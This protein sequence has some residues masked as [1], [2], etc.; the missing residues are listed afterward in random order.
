MRPWKV[1]LTGDRYDIRNSGHIKDFTDANEPPNST[2]G[3]ATIG[4]IVLIV[5]KSGNKTPKTLPKANPP[6]KALKVVNIQNQNQFPK[7]LGT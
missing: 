1:N 7:V 2:I 3:N 5:F 4:I 6:N